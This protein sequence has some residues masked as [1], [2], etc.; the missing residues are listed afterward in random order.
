[1]K[2]P[3][4]ISVPLL[5][6]E[7]VIPHLGKP[8]HW[9]EGRSA[10]SLADSW[11]DAD[12]LPKSIEALLASAPGLNGAELIDGWLERRTDLGDNCGAP[13]QTDLLALLSTGRELV[14][15]AVEAKVDESFGPLVSEWIGS[16]GPNRHKRL[17]GLCARLGIRAEQATSL[18][19][20]LLHRTVAA[21]IEA[22]R[23]H[24]SKAILAV[25][26]F[27]PEA[28]GYD[29]F[30]TFAHAV[31]FDGMEHGRLCGPK[32]FGGTALWIGWVSASHP[33]SI[34]DGSHPPGLS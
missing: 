17:H 3:A 32:E 14:I 11:F 1:V 16:G 8:S 6:A 22:R 25:Q 2:R 27:C 13:P 5:R 33:N 4:R 28:T 7:D 23:F 15:L 18:R 31:G 9:K 21:L 19:Y 26:S 20:Q 24:A 34:S 12:G 30:V 29:D 10:K